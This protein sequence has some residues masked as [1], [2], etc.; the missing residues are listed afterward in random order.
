MNDATGP[1][2]ALEYAVINES[3]GA[4]VESITF[5]WCSYYRAL[6]SIREIV[7]RHYDDAFYWHMPAG[8]I[9]TDPHHSCA[10]CA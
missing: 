9:D 8:R 5:S 1:M 7:A 2:G 4:Q 3:I 6:E 10:A